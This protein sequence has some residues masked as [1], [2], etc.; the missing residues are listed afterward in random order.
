MPPK[1]WRKPKQQTRYLEPPRW[2]DNYS[3]FADK[4]GFLSPEGQHLLGGPII[5]PAKPREPRER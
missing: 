1:G 4:L 5:L 2:R 3:P